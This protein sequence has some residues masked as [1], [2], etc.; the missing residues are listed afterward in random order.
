MPVLAAFTR[1]V[2]TS[3]PGA[4]VLLATV[5]DGDQL[6]YL[7][8]PRLLRRPHLPHLLRTPRTQ[9]RRTRRVTPYQTSCLKQTSPGVDERHR[10]TPQGERQVLSFGGDSSTAGQTAKGRSNVTNHSARPLHP[11]SGD[12]SSI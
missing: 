8:P 1:S 6:P 5:G 7:S 11:S 3:M 2:L 9:Q 12:S 4:A 10:G